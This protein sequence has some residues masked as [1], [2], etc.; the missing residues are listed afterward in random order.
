MKRIRT[1]AVLTCAVG[2]ALAFFAATRTWTT[3]TEA[4][5]APLPPVGTNRTGTA[6]YPWLTA[7]CLV[8]L[9]GAGALLATRG[10]A[11]RAVAVL[12]VACGLG[13][14]G[15]GAVHATTGWALL[16]LAGGAAVV[17]AGAVAVGSSGT[18]PTLGARYERSTKGPVQSGSQ[19]WDALD[20]GDDPTA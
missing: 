8:A 9:A 10:I 14:A 15:A 5:P 20:R 1:L 12:V 16:C 19:M 2:A 7:V 18:W 6:L 17:V 11:R 13:I 3:F 4:R